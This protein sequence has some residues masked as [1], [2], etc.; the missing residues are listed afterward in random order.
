MTVYST[1]DSKMI[2]EMIRKAQK[3]D[4]RA[5]GDLIKHYTVYVDY[6][7]KRY[8]KKTEIKD[9]DDLRS[10]I[11]LGLLLAIRKFNPDKNTRFI[12]FAHT[13]MKK[14][15]FLGDL[16][17]R[18]I[19]LP[20][21]QKVF[22]EKYKKINTRRQDILY[23][24]TILDIEEL[25]E[26]FKE[27]KES[28]R[29]VVISNTST[30]YFTDLS[31]YNEET[32]FHEMSESTL[33]HENIKSLAESDHKLTNEVLRNNINDVLKSF[34]E[35]EVYIIEHLFGLNGKEPMNSEQIA[36]N[37]DVTKVNI[38]FTKTR[39]IRMLRHASFSNQLLNGI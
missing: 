20:V 26:L 24:P 32:G 23:N 18:F 12:Y 36:I 39:V 34:N 22:Y 28:K 37:L 3:G 5:E 10:Y 35:K 25:N 27:S 4:S 17:Y 38:T 9:D 30:E 33:F 16:D 13:W 29:F 21:N 2:L 15:I 31:F 19:R 8:S 14:N 7:I 11:N 1:K 6:M